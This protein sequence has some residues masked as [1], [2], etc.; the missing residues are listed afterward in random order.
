[1]DSP[2][3]VDAAG[4]SIFREDLLIDF[5]LVEWRPGSSCETRDKLI[6]KSVGH[7]ERELGK[8]HVCEEPA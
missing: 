4:V 5:S 1:L 2:K 8:S 7:R 6:H 3:Q